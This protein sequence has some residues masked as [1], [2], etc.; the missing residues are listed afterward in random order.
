[1]LR[2]V[3]LDDER[4]AITVL[5]HK[6]LKNFPEEVEIAGTFDD[7]EAAMSVL[8]ELQPDVLF[9]DVEMPGM[10]GIEL[11][12]QFPNRSFEVVFTTAYQQYAIEAIRR[13][14]LDYLVKPIDEQ[15]LKRTIERIFE[16]KLANKPPSA[17]ATDIHQL[18]QA[19]RNAQATTTKLSIPTSDGL[20]LVPMNDIVRLEASGSYSII[21]TTTKQKI[22]ASKNLSEF[23]E[24]LAGFTNFFR[25]HKSH[26]IN[27]NHVTRYM[28]GEGGLAVMSDGSEAEVARRRKEEFLER[29]QTGR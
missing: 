21:H 5:K 23:E 24:I 16:K 1:M 6:L 27:M 8:T 17:I 11:L 25:T 3:I 19:L 7:P 4:S 26:L 14:A 9:L 22:I 18:A 10:S 28:R 20:L 29:L 12:E 13:S 2:V 15:D